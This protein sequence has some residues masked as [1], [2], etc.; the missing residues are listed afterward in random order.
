MSPANCVVISCA[1]TTFV[2]NDSINIL[3]DL[4]NTRMHITYLWFKIDGYTPS[5]TK[6]GNKIISKECDYLQ[7]PN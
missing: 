2:Y 3:L 4:I 1:Y 5:K 7:N 6:A